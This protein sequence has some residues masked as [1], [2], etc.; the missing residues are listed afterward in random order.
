MT[1][2]SGTTDRAP[3]GASIDVASSVTALTKG[4]GFVVWPAFYDEATVQEA[5]ALTYHLASTEEQRVFHFVPDEARSTQKRV[6]NLIDKGEVFRRMAAD[7][8]LVAVLSGVLGSDAALAS[9]AAN[10]LYPGAPAQEPHADYPFWDLYA[11]DRWPQGAAGMPVIQV[12]TVT[13]LDEFTKE[14]GATWLVP[15]S[16]SSGRWPTPEEFERAAIQVEGPPG[17]VLAFSSTGW[18]AGGANRSQ[19]SRAGLLGCYT[20]KFVKPI[21]D[22]R[23]CL[24]PETVASLSE[25]ER[26]LLALD[27]PYPSVM[28]ERPAENEEGVRAAGKTRAN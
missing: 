11:A 15:E 28:D 10:V 5:R 26:R 21:E 13:M 22:Y 2:P 20:M 17:T 18:H 16:F 1:T 14:N 19:A 27:Y 24:S 7:E 9:Y 4:P 12:E 6:W 3:L 8:R 25:L 23:R